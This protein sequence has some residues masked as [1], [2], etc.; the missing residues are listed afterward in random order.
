MKF[1]I[2]SDPED[3]RTIV[4]APFTKILSHSQPWIMECPIQNLLPEM[5]Y[6]LFESPLSGHTIHC[7]LLFNLCS[8]LAYKDEAKYLRIY[9]LFC[10]AYSTKL[11]P[12]NSPNIPILFQK[13][14]QWHHVFCSFFCS[15]MRDYFLNSLIHWLGDSPF[16]STSTLALTTRRIILFCLPWPWYVCCRGQF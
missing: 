14:E 5:M 16:G 3:E 10:S 1:L 15:T 13:N 2:L 8:P 12:T 6:V 9:P 7:P 11:F 4:V